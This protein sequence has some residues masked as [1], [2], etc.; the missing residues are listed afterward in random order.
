[1][2]KWLAW[3]FGRGRRRAGEVE[4][5]RDC[6]RRLTPQAWQQMQNAAET[7]WPEAETPAIAPGWPRNASDCPG[8]PEHQQA[9]EARK[10][11][12]V[13]ISLPPLPWQ[14]VSASTAAGER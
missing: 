7:G 4:M 11:D 9:E 3:R 8:H 2:P 1:M 13:I 12:L 14:S 6:C 5:V 10:I